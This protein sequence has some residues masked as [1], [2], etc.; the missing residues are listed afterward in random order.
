MEEFNPLNFTILMVD[1]TPKNLQVLGNTLKNENYKLEFATSGIR[2]IEWL[3]KKTF[4]LILLDVMMPEMS[5]FEVCEHIRKD[6][7]YNDLPIIFLT[8][9]TDKE[10]IVKGFEIGAQDYV[11][12]PFDTKELLARV[13]TQLD[14]KFNKEKLTSLNKLLEQKVEERTSELNETNIKLDKANQELRK[15]DKTK[16]EFLR[17]ISHEI[18]TP[19]N[20]ILGPLDLLKDKI[21]SDE[22]MQLVTI[23][24]ASV[25]KLEEYSNK[26]L[27]ITELKSEKES[28]KIH[29]VDL[30]ELLEFCVIELSNQ[31][32]ERNIILKLN[33]SDDQIKIKGDY[34][35]LLDYF[36]I[37]LS[38]LLPNYD[39]KE[40]EII[41][42]YT[43]KD[44]K[45]SIFLNCNKIKSS[46]K[47]LSQLFDIIETDEDDMHHPG[48]D[49]YLSKLILT[50]H[51][52]EVKISGSEGAVIIEIT[53]ASV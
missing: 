10:S 5:G 46:I 15:L 29:D 39:K 14:L 31:F 4:D 32:K 6:K 30:K 2:A 33:H 35:N 24:D 52:G 48:M 49:V 20:G 7:K 19:L 1:D 28:D 40:G 38:N 50:S 51:H 42:T 47:N 53:F 18:R 22:L 26:A 41:I 8:A 21:E 23:L 13:K 36:K 45:I 34:D 9:K 16:N 11:T 43:S 12:K 37:T 25:D 44:D 27:K 17:M 3:E